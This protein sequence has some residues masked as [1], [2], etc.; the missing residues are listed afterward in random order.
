V[1]VEAVFTDAH[2]PETVMFL[3][4]PTNLISPALAAVIVMGVDG[5]VMELVPGRFPLPPTVPK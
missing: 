5:I 2:S 3:E 4:L 1:V